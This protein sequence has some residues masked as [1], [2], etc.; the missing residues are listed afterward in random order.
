LVWPPQGCSWWVVGCGL[1]HSQLRVIGL[2]SSG[3]LDV[4][5]DT[6]G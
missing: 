4:V 5:L 2:A 3:V 1:V 6:F